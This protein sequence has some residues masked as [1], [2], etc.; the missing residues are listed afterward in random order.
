[1]SSICPRLSEEEE[2]I[3]IHWQT[4]KR[5]LTAPL[6]D[7]LARVVHVIEHHYLSDRFDHWI[8]DGSV[9]FSHKKNSQ[10]IVRV[11]VDYDNG[12]SDRMLK[13]P[14]P[15]L[16][17]AVGID[18]MA[19][20]PIKRHRIRQFLR[21]EFEYYCDPE[22]VVR[23][24]APYAVRKVTLKPDYD[25]CLDV[26]FLPEVPKD[27]PIDKNRLTAIEHAIGDGSPSWLF[28]QQ[29]RSAT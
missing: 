25:H 23:P 9:V 2:R 7:R 16:P 18:M 4:S 5:F 29:S 15:Q 14:M 20:G 1:M 8:A 27:I 11:W 22:Q 28:Q 21:S 17:I 12:L 24:I 3:A 13:L 10:N 19:Y 6:L 26:V